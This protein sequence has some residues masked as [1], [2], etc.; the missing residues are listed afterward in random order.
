LH[1]DVAVS[2]CEQGK[3]KG[4]KVSVWVSGWQ[5]QGCAYYSW[6]S[7]SWDLESSWKL[8]YGYVCQWV[9]R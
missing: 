9:S 7:T 3:G 6:L 4:S 1:Y 8:T 5:A 2:L